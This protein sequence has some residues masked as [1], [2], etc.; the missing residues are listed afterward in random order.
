M[1]VVLSLNGRQSVVSCLAISILIYLYSRYLGLLC[2][3]I[4]FANKFAYVCSKSWRAMLPFSNNSGWN[5]L[6]DSGCNSIFELQPVRIA[7]LKK[8]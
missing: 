5:V 4:T 2:Q 7:D 1:L 8:D 3:V 6:L